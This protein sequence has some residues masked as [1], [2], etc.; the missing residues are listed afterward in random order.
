MATLWRGQLD[1][2][3]VILGAFGSG[4]TEIAINSALAAAQAGQPVVLV[5]LDTV[6]PAFR[7]RQAA[8]QLAQ[9]GVRLLAPEGILAGADLPSIPAEVREALA[10]RVRKVLVD[11][12]GSAAGARTVSSLADLTGGA[13]AVS[14]IVV[15][16]WR[17]DTATPELIFGTVYRLTGAARAGPPAIFA[18]LHVMGDDDEAPALMMAGFDVV[19][20]GA[21]LAGVPVNLCAVRRDL[22]AKSLAYLPPHVSV[23]P[24]DLFM[25]PPW[26][27]DLP[28]IPDVP[29]EVRRQEVAVAATAAALREARP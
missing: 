4:K 24:L 10:S 14:W 7:S 11:V 3:T 1:Q 17:P 25:R 20:R 23:L 28:H 8:G 13:G 16:P 5:D 15:N 12:G 21:E 29:A 9:A 2:V 6:T 18:N 22:L 19:M 26:D 27:T